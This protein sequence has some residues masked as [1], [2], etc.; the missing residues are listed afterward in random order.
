MRIDVLKGVLGFAF[1]VVSPCGQ[2][3][4]WIA[5]PYEP[6]SEENVA[7]FFADARNS[8]VA[9]R[10]AVRDA[11][12]TNAVWRVATPGMRDLFVNGERVSETALSPWTPFGRRILEESFDVTTIIRRGGV[13]ELRVELGNGWWNP[14]PLKMWN[15]YDLRKTLAHG[16]PC[17]RAILDLFYD[18]G[19]RESV[20]TD[21]SW[22]AGEGRIIRNSI[23]LGVR[24]DARLGGALD[25]PVRVVEGPQG[26][27]C[28]AA[29]FPKTVVYDRLKAKSVS[30]LGGNRWLVDFG[31]NVAGTLRVKL[32]GVPAGREIRFRQ[33][34]TRNADG[35][36]NVMSAVC[37]QIKDPGI[38]PLHAVAE[39][40]DSWIS[41]GATVTTFE[42]R[43][44]FHVCRYV[45]VEGQM[46]KPNAD[47]FELLAW[48]A[49]VPA[50]AHFECSDER[51][52][53]MHEMCRRTFRANLQS[54]QSDCPGREKF[55][56]GGD[57]AATAESFRCNWG[58]RGFYRKVVRDF[59]D[60]AERYGLFTE[61]AP[62]VGIGLSSVIPPEETDGWCAGPIGWAV[63]VPVMLDVLVRYDGD[64]DIVREAYPALMRYIDR[65]AERYPEDDIPPCL[66]DWIAD[67]KADERL[68]ALAH[69][70][71]MLSK[72]A[73]FARLLGNDA[74]AV[75]LA[76][77]A[78][79]VAKKFRAS[80]L[81]NGQADRTGKGWVNRGVMGEQLFAVY[82]ALLSVE[83][84]KAAVAH[85][86]DD[87]YARG[88]SF[89]TGLFATAYL[90][91][92]LST[93]GYV[94]LAGETVLR[95]GYPG[96]GFM[97][98]RDAT[99]LW[100][101]WADSSGDESHC[102][103][104]LGSVEQWLMRYVLGIRVADDAVGGDRIVI[105]PHPVC[106]LKSASGWL[107]TAKG[108]IVVSWTVV[109]GKLQVV[110]TVPTGIALVEESNCKAK[111][112]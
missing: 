45:Q 66:G 68:T 52:N 91:E 3:A 98:E 29:D 27:I 47:D 22:A 102:H 23:Y 109:D 21:G 30:D 8:V 56:Y 71:E 87:L 34:E 111:R 49:D 31:A 80:Y 15:T 107:E 57:I 67:Q 89:T 69:W 64:L 40:C 104:M 61:T 44:T 90:W 20:E 39:Q 28:P 81:M 70:H 76:D 74:D 105:D 9:K 54:V 42:P 78:V 65:V 100:E 46:T 25:S 6:P 110:K 60:E 112:K 55:G 17:V 95:S 48:S 86:A 33:G 103:P 24:E 4:E 50:A 13:N 32:R 43:F 37:G 83:D 84:A 85:V 88:T 96:Y 26:R 12:V 10:F 94:E 11:D 16:T 51:L 38:G 73:R 93:F 36:V 82:H 63:G 92:V 75:R 79:R 108:R 18:D 72:T 19:T 41:D 59:L 14:L 101:I 35:T 62:Y 5:G 7:A 97:L 1:A 53:R 2:A 106:G 58:M 77:H 99:T